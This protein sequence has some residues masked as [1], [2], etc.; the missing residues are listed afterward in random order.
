[1][2]SGAPS[3]YIEVES[4]MSLLGRHPDTLKI[5]PGVMPIVGRTEQ[6][7]QDLYQQLQDLV[8]P[9][10]GISLL[11][12]IAGGLDLSSYSVDGP[13]P[14]LPPTNSGVSRQHLLLEVARSEGLSI[15]QLYLRMSAARGHHV[16]IG[17]A[18]T[19][20]DRLEQ[21]FTEGAADGFNIMPPYLAGGL[22]DF[23]ELVVPQLQRRGLFRQQYAGRTLRAHLNLWEPPLVAMTEDQSVNRLPVAPPIATREGSYGQN[24]I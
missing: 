6:Q 1:M 2:V 22:D 16:V 9:V 4:R 8:E 14:E 21:W 24:R 13:L 19:I 17:T 3:S 5:M 18:E 15:R 11:S 7:A 20:A 10:V 12:D 23:V